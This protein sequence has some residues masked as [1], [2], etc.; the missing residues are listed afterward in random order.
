ML[1]VPAAHRALDLAVKYSYE[2][3][4]ADG[5]WCGKLRCNATMVAGHVSLRQALELDLKL[6]SGALCHWFLSEKK[7]G[8]FWSLVSGDYPGGIS[9]TTEIYFALKIL[10][11]PSDAAPVQRVRKF[12]IAQGSVEKVRN[13][14]RIYLA[15]FGLFLWNSV[16]ELPAELNTHAGLGSIST[17]YHPGNA[18][19]LC[20][21]SW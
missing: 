2:A 16:P 4:K 21:C 18:A 20:L 12:V 7:P 6:D 15:I 19:R 9:I 3:V 14:M 10:G 5:H 1:L 8:G 11:I 13:L 17:R